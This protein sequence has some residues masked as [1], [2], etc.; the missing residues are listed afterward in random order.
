MKKKISLLFVV[1]A[2]V[3]CLAVL[4]PAGQARDLTKMG[5]KSSY[6]LGGN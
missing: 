2:I 1:V 6:N 3:V 4:T 5:L